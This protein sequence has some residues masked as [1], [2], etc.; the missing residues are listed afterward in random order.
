MRGASRD[1]FAAAGE[2]LEAMLRDGGDPA[3]LA[4]DLDAIA[5][6][7]GHEVS[8]RRLFTDPSRPSAQRTELVDALLGGKVGAPA[9]RLFGET[10]ASRWSQPRDLAIAVELLSV[11]AELAGA[12]RA[13]ELDDVEDELFR[14]SRIVAGDHD[15]TAA[16][17]ARTPVDARAALVDNLL[18]NRATATTRRLAHRLVRDPHGRTV[19]A[20]L[21]EYAVLAADRRRQL[22]ADVRS[23]L[24]L[25]E[26]QHERLVAVLKRLYGRDIHLNVEVDPELIAGVVVRIGDDVIDGSVASRV[27]EASR[28]LAA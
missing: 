15:L 25:T 10:V 23:A 21:E 17:S 18:E 9:Q 19:L 20:G 14:F 27:A 2:R 28:R 24:P 12:E 16:L 4:G 6:L 13:G 26:A 3:A 5:R 1:S 22:V 11:Q 8:L 7:L